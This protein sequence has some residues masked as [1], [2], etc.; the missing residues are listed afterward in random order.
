LADVTRRCAAIVSATL[1]LLFAGTPANAAPGSPSRFLRAEQP[2]SMAWTPDG[3]RLFF[4]EQATGDVRVA[5]PDG[6]VLPQPVAHLD[7]DVSSETGLLGVAVD[8]G[9][10]QQ[11]WIYVYSPIRRSG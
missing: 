9:F 10:P 1:L 6:T 3:T 4:D 11:P 2:V 7:V 8:P 5:T